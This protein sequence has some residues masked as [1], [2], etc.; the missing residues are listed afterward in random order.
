MNR[1]SI[2]RLAGAAVAAGAAAVLIALRPAAQEAGSGAESSEAPPPAALQVALVQ[3]AEGFTHPLVLAASPDG[4]GRLF[5]VDQDGR[6]WIIGRDGGRLRGPFLDVSGRMVRLRGRYDERGL[7]GLAFHPR[8]ARNGRLF[9]Y[10]SAPPR[11]GAPAGTDNTV[12]L[13]EFRVSRESADRADPASERVLL[14]VDEPQANHEGGT[15]AF[16]PDGLLYLGLGDGGGAGDSGPGHVQDWYTPNRGG[17]AQNVQANLLGKILRIDVD[18]PPTDGAPYAIPADNPFTGGPGRPEIWAYG[19][20][21]PYR[22]SFDR[23]GDHG[24]YAADAGQDL[25]EEVDLIERGGN[26]GWN[27]KEGTHCFSTA[28]PRS[29]AAGCPQVDPL[30]HRLIDPIIEIPNSEQPGG[31]GTAVVGGYVYRGQA[32]AALRGRYVFGVW[33]AAEDEPLGRLFTARRPGWQVEEL[34]VARRAEGKL[35]VAGAEGRGLGGYLLGFGEDAGGELYVLT[36][37][38]AGPAGS[39][40][41]VFR[42]EADRAAGR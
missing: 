34:V 37:S 26:Y 18:Q 25:W 35:G 23:G 14:E 6:V 10:Y 9:A 28:H 42:L 12:R 7:L 11:P 32:L 2:L 27:V 17:N 29:P 8:Y 21:N 20:R 39:G 41:K 5:V 16:G 40:G 22:F 30:G 15:V 33:S 13:S 31:L 19:L 3:V 36:A 1:W 4:S 24:L 38:A